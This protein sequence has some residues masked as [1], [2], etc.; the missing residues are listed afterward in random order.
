MCKVV[1]TGGARGLTRGSLDSGLGG[2]LDRAVLMPGPELEVRRSGIVVPDRGDADRLDLSQRV[3]AT[4]PHVVQVH[5]DVTF[6]VY[7]GRAPLAQP[8]RMKRAH[9]VI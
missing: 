7:R 1:K 3:R 4:K 2:D 5:D 8:H 6:V 9:Q